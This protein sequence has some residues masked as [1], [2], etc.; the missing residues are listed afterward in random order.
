MMNA[1]CA[2]FPASC[3]WFFCQCIGPTGGC[4]QYALRKKALNNDMS[5]YSCFQGYSPI[6]FCFK[7]GQCGE[8]SC[9]D[10]C[11]FLEGCFCNPC[12]L[13]A[14]RRLVME[15]YDLTSDPCDYR[16]IRCNNCIQLLACVCDILSII[17]PN[18]RDLS[19][20]LDRIADLVYH[21]ISG[22]M[23]AQ[24]MYCISWYP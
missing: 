9:P 10:L 18:L 22:C 5:K 17:D 6:C 13:S 7:P 3:C 19:N 11:L 16:L 20:L 24:V 23:T 1:P 12:A 8:S 14:T 15:Q 2:E 21:V 4:A